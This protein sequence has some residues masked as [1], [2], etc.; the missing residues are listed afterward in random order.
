MLKTV[1]ILA[2]DPSCRCFVPPNST[3]VWDA[4]HICI[5]QFGQS[6]AASEW[7][8]VVLLSVPPVY[9]SSYLFAICR[10]LESGEVAREQFR[11]PVL[12]CKHTG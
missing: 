5:Q 9:L 3:V 12:H 11:L 10:A 4:E 1:R 2:V 7:L 8:H 6:C